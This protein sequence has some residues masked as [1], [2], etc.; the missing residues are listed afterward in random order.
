MDSMHHNFSSDSWD[1][2]SCKMDY[3]IINRSL[4][5]DLDRPAGAAGM[6]KSCRSQ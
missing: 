1:S 2:R 4:R 5:L 6:H 3:F